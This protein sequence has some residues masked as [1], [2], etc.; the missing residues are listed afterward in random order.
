MEI[1]FLRIESAFR[2]MAAVGDRPGRDGSRPEDEKVAADARGFGSA[3]GRAEWLEALAFGIRRACRWRVPPRWSVGDWRE[4]LRS[5]GALAA[6]EAARDFDPGRG[7]RF[8][9][10]VE[11]RVIAHLLHRYR[12]EWSYALHLARGSTDFEALDQA[13]AGRPPELEAIE[14]RE[15]AARLDPD[16]C[17]LVSILFWE[18]RSESQAAESLGVS[19]QAVSKRKLRILLELRRKLDTPEE[20]ARGRAARTDFILALPAPESG[21]KNRGQAGCEKPAPDQ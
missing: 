1:S 17:R 7:A 8:K 2:S 10:F 12:Q 3:E 11:W 18:G 15:L 14:V 16:D 5:E 20:L 13:A 4:E 19:Q 21:S 9:P 6:W